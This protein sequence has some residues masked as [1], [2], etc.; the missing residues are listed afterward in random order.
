MS[1]TI[2]ELVNAIEPSRTVLFLG[3]GA[4][5][6]SGGPTGADLVTTI[7]RELKYA[8]PNNIAFS[9]AMSLLELSFGRARIVEKVRARLL[10]LKPVGGIA[11][12]SHYEWG[13]IFTTN[14]DQ[15][16]EQSYAR[17]GKDRQVIRSDYDFTPLHSGN[18]T[19]IFKIHGCVSQDIT[20]GHKAGMILTEE[21]Y[22]RSETYRENLF[23]ALYQSLSSLDVIFV[24]YSIS[25]SDIKL[26]INKA[27]DTI[28]ERAY[29]GRVFCLFYDPADE[30]SRILE[31]KGI[32]VA[33]GGID[34]FVAS[35]RV[36]GPA[37]VPVYSSD[38]DL[39]AGI[40]GIRGRLKPVDGLLLSEARPNQM[41]RGRPASYG[42]IA[43]RFV[44][45]RD[46]LDGLVAQ[47]S[48]DEKWI[49]T[50]VG[51]AGVGKTTLARLVLSELQ[52]KG[53]TCFEH[54]DDEPLLPSDLIEIAKR[55]K[56]NGRIAAVFVDEC[57]QFLGELNRVVREL[58]ASSVKPSIRLLLTSNKSLWAPR[59]KDK[60]IFVKGSLTELSALSPAEITSLIDLCE[61][62]SEFRSLMSPDFRQGSRNEKVRVLRGRCSGDMFV[63]LK[64]I[65]SSDSLDE[66][67]LQ[68]YADVPDSAR[69]IY[70]YVAALEAAGVRVHRQLIL[71]T[72]NFP[73]NLVAHTLKELDGIVS[74]YV[75]DVKSGIFGWETRH[76]VIARL[77]ASYKF[78]DLDERYNLLREVVSSLNPVYYIEMRTVRDICDR[79][80]G[81]G[82]LSD[83]EQQNELLAILTKVAPGERVPRHRLIRNLLTKEE[84][85][86][87]ERQIELAEREIG[88]D[89][90]MHRYKIKASLIRSR[91]FEKLRPED[92]YATLLRAKDLAIKGCETYPDDKY[93]FITLCD[94]GFEIYRARKDVTTLND[95]LIRLREAESRILDPQIS[96]EI[97]NIERKVR[98]LQIPVSV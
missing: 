37:A 33:F 21:D 38:D 43:R 61:Q 53:I 25:D 54:N 78:A 60:N 19:R 14:F 40:A 1:I 27:V 15:I 52:A 36:A 84:I 93:N 70:R 51:G 57:H 86:A 95:A 45:Q 81:I 68:E 2:Q 47:L 74:E 10:P 65:F 39:L 41:A 94:V 82:S 56:A 18:M 80:F 34:E 26:V 44:F 23:S 5:F 7:A 30:R 58:S 90:P 83:I 59:V 16:I 72:L 50:I 4:S 97:A 55:F 31:A 24:G 96:T 42:D 87:A 79:D 77:I 66:I 17:A 98:Q 89:A 67:I 9:E 12:I 62:V 20:D 35:L 48:G 6:P 69:E 71:R 85:E 29:N 88:G 73:A 76:S 28:R 64:N 75:V 11:D 46:A 32:R 91:R 49:A 22:A 63:C 92:R 3:A 13:Q 8:L